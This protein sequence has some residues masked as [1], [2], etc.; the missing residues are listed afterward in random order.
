MGRTSDARG[1]LLQAAH[2]LFTLRGY[3]AVGV[4]DLCDR[5]GVRKGSFYHFF[6]SKDALAGAVI[7]TWGAQFRDVL[8][9]LTEEPIPLAAKLSILVELTARGASLDEDGPVLAGPIGTLAAEVSATHPDLRRRI[10]AAWASWQAVLVDWIAAAIERRE[11]RDADPIA[12]AEAVVAYIQGALLLAKAKDDVEVVTR[13][14]A[15][16]PGLVGVRA[17][18]VPSSR[19]G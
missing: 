7:D 3:A 14:G 8:D 19:S 1:R 17:P 2:D 15:R 16:L 6:E 11:L 4:Q 5:A 13:L 10:D 12:T 9:T 18:R